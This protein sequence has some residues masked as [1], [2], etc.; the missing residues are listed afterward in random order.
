MYDII[1]VGAGPA[2]LT[3]SIYAL[4]AGKSVLVLEKEVFGGQI[5]YSPCVENYPGFEKISGAELADHLVSQ[6][7]SLGAQ[8]NFE[9]VLE[10][11][12]GKIKTVVTD[13]H[14]YEC[15]SVII[16]TGARH[17]HLGLDGEE[18]FTGR[19]VSYC[20]VCDGPFY[21]GKE[22]VLVGDGN[23][24]LQYALLLSEYC[25]KVKVCTLFDRFF[26]D[27]SHVTALMKKDN[28]EVIQ[29]VATVAFE[30]D[31]SGLTGV[32]FENRIDK[33]RF[34]IAT[35]ALFVAIGQ[36][37]DNDI[38]S[39][40][41]DLDKYG[42][43]LSDENCTTKTEGLFVAGDCRVKAVRQLTTAAADGAVAALNACNYILKHV[44]LWK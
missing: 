40:L 27:E 39:D 18:R 28:I 38:Y 9:S 36:I 37:P 13:S 42:Y 34:T 20:A 23:T 11:I 3:A 6:S 4:R 7:K 1:V 22:V 33:S 44:D 8:I 21:K 31:N 35:K 2:G 26:G 29:N 30:K 17:R 14:R 10:I 43:I 5:T 16:A 32:V 25:S 41:A 24:A 12:D 15:K 19:G